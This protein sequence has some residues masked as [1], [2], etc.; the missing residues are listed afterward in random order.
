MMVRLS[1]TIVTYQPA[2]LVLSV[3]CRDTDNDL[4]SVKGVNPFFGFLYPDT[5]TG[6]AGLSVTVLAGLGDG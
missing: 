4:P 3:L 1:P 2:V 6:D 5:L